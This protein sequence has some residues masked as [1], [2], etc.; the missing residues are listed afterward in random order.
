MT[1]TS[2]SKHAATGE[3]VETINLPS[4]SDIQVE[5]IGRE[6]GEPGWMIDARRSALA[7][8]R[9]LPMPS[10]RED[11]WRHSDILQFPF[12][13]LSLETL[14][15][16]RK[17]KRAPSAWLRPVAP[18]GTGGRIILEDRLASDTVL[19]EE[20]REAGVIFL[21]IS[22][23]A[24]DQPDLV[25]AL[26]GKVVPPADGKFA[27]LASIIF[28]AGILLHVPK[29]VRIGRPLHI[30]LWSSPGGMRAER[31]L[32]NLE[33]GAAATLF[34]EYASP[35]GKEPAARLQ[36][37]ELSIQAG[38]CLRLFTSQAWGKNIVSV[39]S[40]KASI[41][42]GGELE[43]GFAHFGGRSIK[44][45]AGVD[46]LEAGAKAHWSGFSFLGGNQQANLS[47][48]QNHRARETTSDFLYKEALTDASR[49][50][51]RG[52]VRVDPGAVGADGYQVNRTLLLSEN[53]RAESVP[54]LEILADDVHCSHGVSIGELDEDE[55]FYLRSRGISLEDTQ[56]VLIDGFFEP[57]LGK[58]SQD[59]I[60]RR[61]RGAL[62]EKLEAMR[63]G[64]LP[65]DSS[66]GPVPETSG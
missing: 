54:G 28:D 2:I 50:I 26:L 8:Y 33:E 10:P 3:T 4:I 51:W 52:M 38:A 57:V 55:I 49:S 59:D 1:K 16:S 25:R 22:Q 46:L 6:L 7:E 39:S 56:R 40:E 43:W 37:T 32:V 58:I 13:E 30:S 31:M 12:G 60:R 14:A 18:S 21:P 66:E 63:N 62:E 64:R 23:A 17:P 45:I 61:V 9:K 11:T 36:I 35:D 15:L 41:R 29:G 24:H 19:A 44:T 65:I 53:A 5:A 48:L 27:A 47:S 34:C 20:Y 42:R